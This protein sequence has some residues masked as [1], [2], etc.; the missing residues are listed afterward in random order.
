MAIGD[1][2]SRAEDVPVRMEQLEN[3]TWTGTGMTASG[4]GGARATG[5][6]GQVGVSGP[7]GCGGS[8]ACPETRSIP[9]TPSIYQKVDE[10]Y[11]LSCRN[12]QAIYDLLEHYESKGLRVYEVHG[13]AWLARVVRGMK[14]FESHGHPTALIGWIYG[15]AIKLEYKREDKVHVIAW[16]T[17][18]A[19]CACLS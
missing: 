6:T 12:E 17:G 13:P 10:D 3:L 9:N 5:I 4:Y 14:D 11:R 1:H 16:P 15:V 7:T 18:N 8:G 2:V 19:Y